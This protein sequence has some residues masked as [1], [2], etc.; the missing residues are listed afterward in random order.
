MT[1]IS[2][3]LHIVEL[4]AGTARSAEPFRAWPRAQIQLLVDRE[5]LAAETYRLNYPNAPY[6]I[7][8]LTRLTAKDI[9]RLAG[10]RVDVLL[11]CPPCTGFS[12]TGARNLRAFVNSHLTRFSQ[13]A[14]ELQ[15]LAIAVENVPIAGETGRFEAFVRRL[16]R[17]GYVS[18]YGILNAALR[19]SPQCRHRLLYIGIRKDVGVS[20]TIPDATH[21]GG[22][23][24]SYRLQRVTSLQEDRMAI[25]SE[26]P[27]AR[28]VR[29]FMPFVEDIVGKKWIPTV[30]DAVSDLPRVGSRR[31]IA[32]S[33]FR[34]Q[35]TPS[36]VHRM[37]RVAE[38]ARWRGGADHFSHAYGRLHR[39]GLARTITTYFSNPGSGRF[40]HPTEER[41]LSLREAARL[42]GIPDDFQFIDNNCL[43]ACRLIG[44]AL[45][46]RLAAVA[47]DVI[48]Q[49]LD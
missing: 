13:L 21:G 12:D 7:H 38:G 25:L 20:P 3:K 27:G 10:G 31:G 36:L 49:A 1:A 35:H 42:Q 32:L 40:W 41:A 33:H 45:D 15:P 5:R 17:A 9:N 4:Y 47:Y 43:G 16:D 39:R 8:D 2:R 19:G 46:S 23:Y 26:A 18:T 24:F 37:S 14:A 30:A 22:Q 6:L 48:R 28:R 34:W 29:D 11:G 44:N